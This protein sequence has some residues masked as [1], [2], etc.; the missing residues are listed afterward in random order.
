MFSSR[1]LMV[2]YLTFKALS[3][4]EFIFVHGMKVCTNF[5]D[6]PAAV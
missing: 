5:T 4:F 1:S 6:L 3:H 2:S